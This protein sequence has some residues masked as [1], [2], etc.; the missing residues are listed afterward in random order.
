[1]GRIILAKIG[2]PHGVRGEV[3]VKS[4]TEDPMALGGYGPLSTD[5][6]ARLEIERMRQAKDVLIVKFRG[7]GDR[8]A[9]ARL[10]GRTL[11][12]ERSALPPPGEDEFYH[13][14][15][16]GLA[17]VDP[18]GAT[19]GR[20]AAVFNHGAGD[21][22]EIAPEA[23]RPT[24]LVPFTRASVPDIDIAGGRL[25]IV[26]PD[27]IEVPADSGKHPEPETGKEEQ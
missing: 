13:A 23:G 3:R 14:D 26:P 19:L 2:A 18:D 7:I 10:N 9:A 4:F 25:V 15:L 16:I 12:I 22:L 21:F 11:T 20:V 24:L 27:E 1:M 5:E 8:D 6:G 17:A